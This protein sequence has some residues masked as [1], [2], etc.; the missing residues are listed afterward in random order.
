MA[1]Y[2]FDVTIDRTA[3]HSTKWA[4]FGPDV[5]P[6]WVAD[7]D[8]SAP[9][10]MLAAI[11]ERLDHGVLGYT[12]TPGDLIEAFIAWLADRY[13]WPVQA[14]WLVWLPA[15]VPGM[16]LAARAIGAAKQSVLVPVPVYHPFLSVPR[17]ADKTA[18][19]VDLV[20]DGGRWR[21]NLDHLEAVVTR[22][23]CSLLLCSPHN[24]TGRVYDA[25]EV[26]A[27]V[28][29]CLRHDLTLVS[30]EIH[31]QLV[32]DGNVSHTPP[33]SLTTQL[34]A[35]TLFSP[36]KAYNIPGLGSAVAVIPDADLRDA[37]YHARAGLIANVSPLAYT[38]AH[39][40]YTDATDWLGA[41][42]D[43][44]RGNRDR[45]EETVDALPGIQMAHVEGTY[46]GWL[47][48]RALELEAPA[49]HFLGHGLGLSDGA[50]FGGPGFQRFNF[51]CPRATLEE[52]L[53][54]LERAVRDG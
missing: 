3:T 26:A 9:P 11:R 23:T 46:L 13:D 5:L 34:R 47:D 14:D 31:C 53:S 40:A 17:H 44:L 8:F 16:N 35:I 49:E 48:V 12:E 1:T 33:A 6:F 43:Y 39:W 15:V 52:G 21:L 45:L 7:M 24:P 36:N 38:A 4:R 30:D 28:D 50:L 20:Q 41:L 2:N 27:L 18:I 10:Q 51:A 37:F 25:D 32:L 29:F 54:R 22:Q 42:L 19:F